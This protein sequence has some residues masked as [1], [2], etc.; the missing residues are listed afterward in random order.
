LETRREDDTE[1]FQVNSYRP[2]GHFSPHLDVDTTDYLNDDEKYSYFQMIKPNGE[3]MATLMYYLSDV[4][5]GGRTVFLPNWA[6]VLN[7]KKVLLYCGF[8]YLMMVQL[9]SEGNILPIK[10]IK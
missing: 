1:P 6:L 10:F 2:G 5:R 9:I 8:L 4:L 3:R 7:Q